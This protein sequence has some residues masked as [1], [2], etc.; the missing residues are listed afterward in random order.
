MNFNLKKTAYFFM[1]VLSVIIFLFLMFAIYSFG[2]T[3]L[4][5]K[6]TGGLSALNYPEITGHLVIM[7]FGLGCFYFCLKATQKLKKH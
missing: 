2:E 3:L 7:F 1:M 6:S 4:Y 5:I